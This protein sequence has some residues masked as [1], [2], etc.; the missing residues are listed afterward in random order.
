MKQPER[1]IKEFIPFVYCTKNHKKPRNK[2][3]QIGKKSV[4][5]KL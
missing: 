1:E 4:L 3:N 2:P 5:Q